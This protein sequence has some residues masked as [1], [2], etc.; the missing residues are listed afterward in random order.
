[1]YASKNRNETELKDE[2]WEDARDMGWDS[3][4]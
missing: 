3:V 2:N 4:S 1:M